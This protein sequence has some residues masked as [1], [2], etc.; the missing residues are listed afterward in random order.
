MCAYLWRPC[1]SPISKFAPKHGKGHHSGVD[2]EAKVV[3]YIKRENIR[4]G[5]LQEREPR[6]SH[7]RE[8]EQPDMPKTVKKK[9][10]ESA[11]RILDIEFAA[12]GVPPC[13]VL[14]VLQLM[15]HL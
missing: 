15:C 1:S 8:R 5:I 14:E 2:L 7:S 10:H 11:C 4:G 9:T 13:R 6:W 12:A 3:M